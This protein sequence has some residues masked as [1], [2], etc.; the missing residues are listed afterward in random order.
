MT[1][2]N[3]DTDHPTFR[4][5]LT[6]TDGLP[7]PDDTI[8]DPIPLVKLGQGRTPAPEPPP[9]PADGAAASLALVAGLL[10]FV[11][12]FAWWATGYAVDGAWAGL[13]F[14]VLLVGWAWRTR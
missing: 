1:R 5:G 13:A 3:H 6:T 10:A 2:P 9:G 4:L 12:L 7:R 14:V 8:A 11:S